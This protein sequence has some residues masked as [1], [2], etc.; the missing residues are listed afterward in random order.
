MNLTLTTYSFSKKY[1]STKRPSGG[2]QVSVVWKSPYSTDRPEIEVRGDVPADV[3]YAFITEFNRYYWVDANR[4][5]QDDGHAILSLVTDV[6]A[7]YKPQIMNQIFFV[8]RN[9]ST[10]NSSYSDSRIATGGSRLVGTSEIESPDLADGAFAMFYAEIVGADSSGTF[11]D[12][13]ILSPSELGGIAHKLMADTDFHQAYI[14]GIIEAYDNPT[15]EKVANVFANAMHINAGR[16]VHVASDYGEDIY[17]QLLT[18]GLGG[19]VGTFNA[20]GDS[21]Q[22][23]ILKPMESIVRIVGLACDIPTIFQTQRKQ[24][25]LGRFDSGVTGRFLQDALSNIRELSLDIPWQYVSQDGGIADFRNR[26]EYTAITLVL[27]SGETVNLPT[28]RLYNNHNLTV[29]YRINATNGEVFGQCLVADDVI[30]SFSFSISTPVAVSSMGELVGNISLGVITSAMTAV[31]MIGSSNPSMAGLGIAQIG[32]SVSNMALESATPTVKGSSSQCMLMS[33][34]FTL[35]VTS[36]R[37]Q[38]PAELALLGRPL[39]RPVQLGSLTGFTVC[40]NAYADVPAT[41]D[42]QTRLNNFLNTGFYI[43]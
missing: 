32:S 2:R 20:L 41:Y 19:I 39:R 33:K 10:Y 18:G 3:N 31:P 40:E 16:V 13:Y 8:D 15:L 12:R 29:K 11:T 37:T 24:I 30:A 35:V 22:E 43:E 6:L 36:A 1:N 25:Y 26:A 7:T 42:E 5:Y 38:N 4:K 9:Q 34:N 21:L 14:D 23:A 17:K 28:N 27:P